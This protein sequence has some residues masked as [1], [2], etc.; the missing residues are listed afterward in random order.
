MKAPSGFVTRSFAGHLGVCIF[1]SDVA[2]TMPV[3]RMC[4]CETCDGEA[5]RMLFALGTTQRRRILG[6]TGGS[7]SVGSYLIAL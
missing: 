4:I 7:A 2:D 3:R 6:S 1:G 5:A